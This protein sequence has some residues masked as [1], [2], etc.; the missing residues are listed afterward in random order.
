MR[1][2]ADAPRDVARDAEVVRTALAATAPRPELLLPLLLDV[3]TRLG[4]VP[5][6]SI[7]PI[8]EHFNL[9]RADVH[10]V[11]T[12]YHDLRTAPRAQHTVQICQAEACQAVGCRAL[13]R[14]A[15]RRLGVAL[16]EATADGA[17]AIEAAYCF[18]N[19]ACGPAVRIGD[20]IHGRVDAARFDEL[21]DALL[22][23]A[24]K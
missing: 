5:A 14:H 24:P 21:I 3:Q 11:A 7:A 20:E 10:G 12:F 9:S 17:I 15:E 8:A 16:G 23:E 4:C 19:C 13:A 22:R 1:K 6:E 18:G 2:P